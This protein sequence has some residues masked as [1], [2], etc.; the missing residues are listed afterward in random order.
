[1]TIWSEKLVPKP[2]LARICAR[3]SA[4][5]GRGVGQAGE[6]QVRIGDGRH[7]RGFPHVYR[8]ALNKYYANGN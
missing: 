8:A 5:V 2:G 1:M 6:A 4:D 7:F 3:A